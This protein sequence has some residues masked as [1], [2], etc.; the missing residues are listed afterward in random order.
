MQ[1]VRVSGT[2]KKAEEEAIRRARSSIKRA[3]RP[4]R[5]DGAMHAMDGHFIAI[6]EKHGGFNDLLGFEDGIEDRDDP[7]EL[8]DNDG[9]DE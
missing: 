1:V 3:Q 6:N 8:E 2:I 5:Q 4:A 9:N 7:S